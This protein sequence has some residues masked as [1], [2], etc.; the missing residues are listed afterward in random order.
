M[1]WKN[2]DKAVSLSMFWSFSYGVSFPQTVQAVQVDGAQLLWGLSSPLGKDR[3][4]WSGF[5]PVVHLEQHDGVVSF[6]YLPMID[7]NLAGLNCIY[8]RLWF[9]EYVYPGP[10]VWFSY[11][12]EWSWCHW[13]YHGW[14]WFPKSF[15]GKSVRQTLFNT[16]L[17]PSITSLPQLPAPPTWC[18]A[19][20][21]CSFAWKPDD[22][23]SQPDW[24]TFG[25]VNPGNVPLRWPFNR[26][27]SFLAA[28]KYE[29]F[30][31]CMTKLPHMRITHIITAKLRLQFKELIGININFLESRVTCR[32]QYHLHSL[33]CMLP[34][35]AAFSPN[36]YTKS[37]T[38]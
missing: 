31:S 28:I 6:H 37:V 19:K 26:A 22:W 18:K 29:W 24:W 11:H 2:S 9:T 30:I 27:H 16:S 4:F 7:M 14:F 12:H 13:I 8:S 33:H 32:F 20:K 17:Q 36:C 21:C 15:W 25:A 1:C 34:Y 23:K 10:T 38:L 5:M 35:L 3:P